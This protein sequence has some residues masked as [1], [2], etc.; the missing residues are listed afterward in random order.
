MTYTYF[1][2]EKAQE[3]YEE[4]LNWYLERSNEVAEKFVEAFDKAIQF[5]CSNPW[6]GRNRY[7]EFYEVSLERFPF[8][9]IYIVEKETLEIIISAVYHHKR[10]PQTKYQKV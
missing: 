3:E 10:N 7:K 8:S 5:I 6:K 2:Y 4:S 9:I 1:F